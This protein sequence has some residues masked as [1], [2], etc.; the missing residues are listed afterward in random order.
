MSLVREDGT[1]SLLNLA[2]VLCD[3]TKTQGVTEVRLVDHN[4]TAMTKARKSF[5]TP[6]RPAPFFPERM[7]LWLE[8]S[9]LCSFAMSWRLTRR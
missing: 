8:K 3:I 9:F 6:S 4:L 1:K 7:E 2:E 5:F